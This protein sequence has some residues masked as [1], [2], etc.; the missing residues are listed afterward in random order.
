MKRRSDK[1]SYDNF[2]KEHP[3]IAKK[4][5]K[6]LKTSI[7]EGSLTSVSVG[8]G[9]SYLAPFALAMQATSAQ[10]GILHAIASLVPSV[11]QLGSCKLIQKFSR[12]KTIVIGAAIQALLWIPIMLTSL[13]YFNNISSSIW[14]FITLVGLFYIIGGLIHPAWFSL[15][16]SLVPD[17][18]RGEYFSQRNKAAQFFGIITMIA[19]AIFLDYMKNAG[20]AA[21]ETLGYTLLGFATLFT[22]AMIIRFYSAALLNKHYEP[23]LKITKKDQLS[24][25]KFIKNSRTNPFGRFALFNASLWVAIGI[26]SPFFVVYMLKELNLSYIWYTLIIISSVLFQIIF[27]TLIGKISDR[28]G[29][30][31]LTKIST[32]LIALTPLA[33]AISHFI[34]GSFATKLYLIFF[35]Q[36]INGIGWAGFNIATNN[37]VYDSMNQARQG[38]ALAYMNLFV[39][40]GAFFGAIIGTI[41]IKINIFTINIIIIVFLIS[42]IARALVVL[43]GSRYLTEVKKVKKF[44]PS[45]LVHEFHPL[46]ETITEV[47]HLNHLG[48]K[49]IHYD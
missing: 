6:T 49:I 20:S 12:K 45:F 18:K 35:A 3:K 47:H 9:A 1:D 26:A 46:R 11:S 41:L 15:M 43:I 39:G 42:F 36:L 19:S 38:Y 37:F 34:P 16:G 28:F 27:L 32:S 13:L 25:I 10:I 14:I 31:L 33:W 21:G 17:K 48:A 4:I 44:T 22:L 5:N 2:Q 24:L 7:T 40:M 29:N 23:K 30:I 8:L